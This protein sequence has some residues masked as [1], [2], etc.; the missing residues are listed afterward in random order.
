MGKEKTAK[1]ED[2][3]IICWCKEVTVRQIR[4]AVENGARSADAVSRVT[5][6]GAGTECAVKNPKGT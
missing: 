3:E 6:A 4:D 2:N 1:F 5:G